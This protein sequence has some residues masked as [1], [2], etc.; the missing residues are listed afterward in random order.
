M[1]GK[2]ISLLDEIREV[3]QLTELHHEM[4]MG[5]SFLTVDKGDDVWVMQAFEYVD[6]GVEVL[7]KLL[8]ELVQVD[9]LDSDIAW[10]LL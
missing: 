8:V 1:P 4:Y 7:F 6:L 2:G 5:G 9:R 3:S 10:L